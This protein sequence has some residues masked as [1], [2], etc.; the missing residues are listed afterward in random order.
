VLSSRLKP[1]K[2]GS[3]GSDV[4]WWVVEH[5]LQ[6]FQRLAKSILALPPDTVNY[7][8]VYCW[9]MWLSRLILSIS[10]TIASSSAIFR[11]TPK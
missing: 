3:G 6:Y 7:E 11:D 2:N 10:S 5:L 8:V 4:S 1:P 9:R